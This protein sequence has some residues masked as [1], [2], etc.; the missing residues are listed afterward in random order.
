VKGVL[1]EEEERA[2]AKDII[3]IGANQVVLGGDFNG[4]VT[5]G[6]QVDMI[7]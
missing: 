1:E 7:V 2:I 3:Q 4:P 6:D 5:I